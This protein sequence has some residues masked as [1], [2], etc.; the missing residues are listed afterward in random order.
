MK[1]LIILLVF[2]LTQ[3]MSAQSEKNK[4][5]EFKVYG[6]CGMCKNRIEKALNVEG[7]GSAKWD[8]KTDVINIS[9]N[10]DKISE[11][12]LHQLIA[13]SGHDTE[14]FTAEDK[15]YNSLPACCQYDRAEAS[16][17]NNPDKKHKQ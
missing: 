4:I 5:A 11:E 17:E 8:K 1:A 3:L 9:Y 6:N 14:K 12:K 2:S 10:S 13:D 15:V 16:A 7:V